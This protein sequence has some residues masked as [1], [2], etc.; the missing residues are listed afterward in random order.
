M[1]IEATDGDYIPIALGLKAAG[2][3]Q[4]VVILK[5][6]NADRGVEFIHIDKL[7][8]WMYRQMRRAGMQGPAWWEV[9]LFITLLGLCSTDFTRNLPLVTPIKM[10]NALPLI[11]RTFE[12]EGGSRIHMAQGKHIVELLYSEAF[13]KHIDPFSRRSVWSQVCSVH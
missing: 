3:D 2:F 11:V 5:A 6:W 4:P 9:R 1:L 7:H 12:M 10:W 8:A 13:P